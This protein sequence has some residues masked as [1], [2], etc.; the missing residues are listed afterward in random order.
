MTE[1]GG[2]VQTR[3]RPSFSQAAKFLHGPA[4]QSNMIGQLQ[5]G[6]E[7]I[8]ARKANHGKIYGENFLHQA[9]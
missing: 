4:Y 5:F 2:A 8:P 7:G 6:K 3:T 9:G 1:T